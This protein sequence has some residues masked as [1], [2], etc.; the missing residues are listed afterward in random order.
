[1]AAAK[2]VVS[3]Q[4]ERRRRGGNRSHI[5]QLNDRCL[6]NAYNHGTKWEDDD[7]AK[8]ANMIEKDKTTFDM[9]MSLGRSYYSTQYARSHVGF[10]MRH[11]KV[12]R[13]ILK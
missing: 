12:F 6:A 1:M 2:K 4:E 9:A 7:V 5:A 8:L 3:I 13:R 11:A 10:A